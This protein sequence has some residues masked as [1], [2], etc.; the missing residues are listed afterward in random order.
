MIPILITILTYI[1]YIFIT[2]LACQILTRLTSPIKKIIKKETFSH[3]EQETPIE[4][5]PIEKPQQS[6]ESSL[7]KQYEG[8]NIQILKYP[9]PSDA[10]V[11]KS[12][13]ERIAARK[14]EKENDS[15]KRDELDI[16][17]DGVVQAYELKTGLLN[18]SNYELLGIDKEM[19]DIM[20]TA[21]DK[22]SL[23]TGGIKTQE[24]AETTRDTIDKRDKERVTETVTDAVVSDQVVSTTENDDGS[25][26]ENFHNNLSYG[27]I[28]APYASLEVMNGAPYSSLE[29]TT[30]APFFK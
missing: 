28:D 10:E 14:S 15:Y 12:F 23:T 22:P 13:Q 3:E 19:A 16:N 6:Y 25:E 30:S 5:P 4:E 2:Y 8:S 9:N 18:P 11:M 27:V 21:L 20:L 1:P 7:D 24:D 26:G 29:V 17:N